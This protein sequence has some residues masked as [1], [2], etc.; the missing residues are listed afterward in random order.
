MVENL[1][2]IYS[3]SLLIMD[4]ANIK[5]YSYNHDI[6]FEFFVR[7]EL[8]V[9]SQGYFIR[10]NYSISETDNYR[11]LVL[12]HHFN[13]LEF[14]RNHP[15]QKGAIETMNQYRLIL[16]TY[17]LANV[18]TKIYGTEYPTSITDTYLNTKLRIM[19]NMAELTLL[20]RENNKKHSSQ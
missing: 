20:D 11:L 13:D 8:V 19:K 15:L 5:E 10:E 14:I 6:G 9:G 1:Y 18:L 2:N 16:K 3:N 4:S 12:G 7:K 17:H